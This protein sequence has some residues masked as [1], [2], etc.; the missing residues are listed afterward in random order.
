MNSSG[1][2]GLYQHDLAYKMSSTA[3]QSNSLNVRNAAKSNQNSKD[4]DLPTAGNN[5]PSSM[6]FVTQPSSQKM[7]TNQISLQM[8][9]KL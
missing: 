5:N 6:Q 1:Q 3:N 4:R 7:A 8:Q 9:K 2:D